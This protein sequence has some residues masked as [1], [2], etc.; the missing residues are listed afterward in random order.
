MKM[1]SGSTA[2]RFVRFNMVGLMGAA[3][4]LTALAFFARVLGIDPITATAAAVETAVV[5]NFIWHERFTWADR[6]SICTPART[7]ESGASRLPPHGRAPS[8]RAARL[9]A[10][11]RRLA[12]F[13]VTNGA[14]SLSG[15][16]LLMALLIHHSALPLVAADLIAVT[17]CAVVN[18]MLSDRLVF[19]A[20]TGGRGR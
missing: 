5:H 9:A 10:S 13:N 18:F 4:Q 7:M 6:V 2:H 3:V 17:V 16:V 8:S 19:R 1:E 12:L 14:V 15:N 11:L 20:G